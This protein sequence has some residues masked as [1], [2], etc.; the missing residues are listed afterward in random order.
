MSIRLSRNYGV[1][2]AIFKCYVCGKDMGILMP[3]SQ[4]NEFKKVG[5]ADKS[6]KMNMNIGCINKEPCNECKRI[7]EQGI[8]FISV[9]DDDKD[10]RTGGWCAI[11]EE[12]VRRMGIEPTELLES[13]CE[14]RV[15]FV[16]D[17]VYD[18][19]GLPRN[20]YINNMEE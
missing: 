5:L 7:M 18:A 16:Q 3:G 17:S 1:N 15:C 19:F 12:A 2:P 4:T 11:K 10:Y 14:N 6:G 9:K 8:I 13:I 20:Q